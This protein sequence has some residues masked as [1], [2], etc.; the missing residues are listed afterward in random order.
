MFASGR[1][2]QRCPEPDGRRRQQRE[3]V[4]RGQSV[5]VGGPDHHGTRSGPQDRHPNW[6]PDHKKVVYAAGVGF[7]ATGT[8]ALYIKD[9][10]S[11]QQTL[12]AAAAPDQDRP[13]WSPDGTRIAYGSRGT[14]W[15]R[16]SRRGAAAT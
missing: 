16:A 5:R 12:F 7:N 10:V 6:S 11:G 9:L 15:S 3:A 13:T 1:G 14:I 4:G 2:E 8:Y